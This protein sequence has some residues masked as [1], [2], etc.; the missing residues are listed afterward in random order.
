MKKFFQSSICV[1]F[2]RECD[3]CSDTK[4]MVQVLH[5]SGPV[6]KLSK[7]FNRLSKNWF[8]D[9]AMTIVFVVVS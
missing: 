6:N 5:A 1:A 8:I 2:S 4:C 9:C 3:T 7:S